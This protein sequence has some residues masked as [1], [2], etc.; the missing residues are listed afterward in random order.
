MSLGPDRRL[1]W[2]YILG[3]CT[4][5]EKDWLNIRMKSDKDLHAMYKRLLVYQKTV[6]SNTELEQIQSMLKKRR[7]LTIKKK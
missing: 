3:E 5:A 6:Q 4:Q 1:I 2:K 7:A